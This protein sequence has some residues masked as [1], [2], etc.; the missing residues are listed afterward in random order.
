MQLLPATQKKTRIP[1]ITQIVSVIH[2]FFE[3]RKNQEKTK[4]DYV[5]HSLTAWLW[6][7]AQAKTETETGFSGLLILATATVFPFLS[8]H[9]QRFF[10]Q[11]KIDFNH[12]SF[13]N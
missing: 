12:I 2:I 8:T 4:T 13:L 3:T 9:T 10:F 11:S 5:P 1:G 6:N 7:H